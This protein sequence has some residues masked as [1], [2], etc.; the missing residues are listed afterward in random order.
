MDADSLADFRRHLDETGR[1]FQYAVVRH[2]GVSALG[3]SFSAFFFG[4][5]GEARAYR[6]TFGGYFHRLRMLGSDPSR[7][8]LFLCD[9]YGADNDGC[10]YAGEKGDLFVERATQSIIT[11]VASELQVDLGQAVTV[12]SSMG[13]TGALKF[14]LM[15]GCKGVVAVGPHID[16]DTS[17]ATQNRMRHVAYICP[18]GDPLPTHNYRYTRQIR[19]LVAQHPTTLPRLFMQTCADDH[20]VYAEQVLPLRDQWTAK[21]GPVDLDVRPTGGHTSDFAPRALLL[22]AIGRLER[23]EAIP[24]SDYQHEEQFRGRRTRPPLALRARN[25][26][27]TARNRLL[28]RTPG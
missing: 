14:G 3:I 13:G 24:V 15:N 9:A 11:S 6:D 17:A 23:D 10:Y 19:A 16:L 28:R 5:W 20:G 2:P 12:G 7:N 21:G 18:D 25:V 27:G 4:K 1:E 22:D 8:W 26:L